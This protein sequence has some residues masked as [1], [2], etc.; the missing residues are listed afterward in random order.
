M[1]IS[2]LDQMRGANANLRA[3]LSRTRNSLAG[4]GNFNVED[5]LAIAEPVA[6]VQPIIDEAENFRAMHPE[7]AVEL[8]T[9]KGN[10]EEMQ[11]ALEQMRVMLT[12]RR[13]QIE[14]ARGRLAT[15]NMWNA[16]LLLTR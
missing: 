16:A 8:D 11:E 3:L 15:L 4:C 10:L 13:A 9:Y 2:I 5:V 6:A 14:A 7:L 1:E 12:T